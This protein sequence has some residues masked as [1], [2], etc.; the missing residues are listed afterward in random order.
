[1]NIYVTNTFNINDLVTIIVTLISYY[2]T[3]NVQ[4]NQM[5]TYDDIDKTSSLS[6]ETCFM[7]GDSGYDDHKLY[8][9]SL[10]EDLN[11]YVQYKD[12]TYPY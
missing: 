11:W 9:L 8:D 4:D 12:I 3:A 5:N 2:K 7:I 10:K 6:P 1:M